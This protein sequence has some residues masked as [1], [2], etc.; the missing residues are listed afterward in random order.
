M[1]CIL[2][3]YQIQEVEV[4]EE[5]MLVASSIQLP[6]IIMRSPLTFVPFAHHPFPTQ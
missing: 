1:L 6:H 3:T 5:D 2:G 4:T